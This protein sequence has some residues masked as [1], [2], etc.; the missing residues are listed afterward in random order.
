MFVIL[1]R[2]S[3]RQSAVCMFVILVKTSDHQHK[4]CMFIILFR[5]FAYS[6]VYIILKPKNK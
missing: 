5:D 2:I 1:V 4:V 3:Y 6:F